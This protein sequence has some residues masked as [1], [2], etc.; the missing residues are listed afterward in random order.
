MADDSRNWLRPVAILSASGDSAAYY[1]SK[2]D[3]VDKG[4]KNHIQDT[5]NRL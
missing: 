4:L 3:D 1:P 2:K 5:A